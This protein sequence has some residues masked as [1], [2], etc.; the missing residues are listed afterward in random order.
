MFPMAVIISFC[1]VAVEALTQGCNCVSTKN[2]CLP[3]VL[4]DSS[5]YY[6][7]GDIDGLSNG[8]LEILG[9]STEEKR[10]FS[11]M[12]KK[13]ALKFSWDNAFSKTINLFERIF[14][15]SKK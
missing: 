7:A 13:R 1:F 8:I 6:D 10:E 4:D 9:R 2:P 5:L 15:S 11:D 3:E 14:F 12:A